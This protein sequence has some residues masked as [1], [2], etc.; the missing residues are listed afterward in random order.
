MPKGVCCAHFEQIALQR[1]DSFLGEFTR[2][3]FFENN[4]PRASKYVE[5]FKP[6]KACKIKVV[7]YSLPRV[8]TTDEAKKVKKT[9]EGG[10]STAI[11]F[12][13]SSRG[14]RQ[15]WGSLMPEILFDEFVILLN[16]R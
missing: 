7:F 6:R 4:L 2:R 13:I 9:S 11:L 1:A 16:L 8:S 5:G 3:I 14:C 12:L 15:G 10:Q